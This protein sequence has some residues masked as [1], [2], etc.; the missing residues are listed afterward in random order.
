MPPL[1]LLTRPVL[2]LGQRLGL[3]TLA[4]YMIISS[5]LVVVRIVQLAIGH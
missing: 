1:S 5:V 4:T 2:N 3:G